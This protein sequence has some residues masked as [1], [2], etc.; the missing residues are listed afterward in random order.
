MSEEF[1]AISVFSLP[2]SG[3]SDYENP[4]AYTMTKKKGLA[5]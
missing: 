5:F 3:K 2:D 4:C 1:E